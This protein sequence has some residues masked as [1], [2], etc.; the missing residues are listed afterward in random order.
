MQKTGLAVVILAA[1]KGTRMHSDQAKVLHRL[2]S[3]PMLLYV[4]DSVA[5]LA[6]ERQIVV[7][8]YGAEE[9]ETACKDYGVS[10]VRQEQQLGTGHAAQQ[11][12]RALSD[13]KGDVLILCGDMPLLKPETL[14]SLVTQHRDS[15]AACTLLSLKTDEVRDFGRV[16]RSPKGVV[17]RIVEHRDASDREKTID[18]YNA[19]VYCFDKDILFKAL[20]ALDN[21]N[22]QTEYY[23]T[24][25][26]DYLYREGLSIQSLQ[27]RDA[28]EIFGINS[29]EDLKRAEAIMLQ[30][31]ADSGRS[32]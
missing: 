32:S 12:D 6:P 13:F 10:F 15:K 29:P 24:D 2:E 23:L 17:E 3:R 11:A 31:S 22:A 30:R 27:T 8:G 5:A 21:N 28:L 19:G 25:T 26:I 20:E 1:G 18:E 14:C 4:L 7:V 16:V 9:V